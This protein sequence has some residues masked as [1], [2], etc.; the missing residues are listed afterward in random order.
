[1]NGEIKRILVTVKAYPNPSKKYGETVCV[2]GVDIDKGKWM[3]LYPI[4][5]RDLDGDKRFKKYNI[6][7]IRAI[8]ARDDKRP[9]SFKVDIDSIKILDHLDTKDK[10]LRRKKIVLPTVDDSMCEIL[11]KNEENRKSL[12]VFKP[13]NVDFICE[14][15]KPKDQRTREAC[16][17]QLSFL[18]KRKNTIE[19]IPFDFRYR[20]FCHNEPLC[21]GHNFSNIDWEIGQ[22]Y[23]DWRHIYKPESLL[24]E[25]IKER[26]LSRMC[27]VK[28]DIYFFVGNMHR[29]PTNFMIL[30]VFYPPKCPSK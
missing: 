1:M 3:R 6:I 8:K 29:F 25:K 21:Q 14:K 2:A 4:P 27:S 17:A 20:F 7:Q 5:Y 11:R 30:G 23:R 16:Y 9:E 28:N 18:N 15:A 26:W 22:A 12:G 24:L 10:W 19:N 13:A